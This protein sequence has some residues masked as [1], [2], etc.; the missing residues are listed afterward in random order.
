M[1]IGHPGEPAGEN[2]D[3]INLCNVPSVPVCR[4]RVAQT[5]ASFAF[6]SGSSSVHESSCLGVNIVVAVSMLRTA[7]EA[8]LRLPLRY[9]LC[10][11]SQ[12]SP[13]PS[14]GKRGSGTLSPSAARVN[15]RTQ[16]MKAAKEK[17][18]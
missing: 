8:K 9:P 17:G 11:S 4:E 3:T 16:P 5:Y 18:T 13:V 1:N 2:R 6:V 14:E 15:A 10:A 12:L 7:E